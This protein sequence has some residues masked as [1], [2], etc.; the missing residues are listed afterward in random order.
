MAWTNLS[1]RVANVDNNAA[2]DIN[3]VME[4]LRL[5]KGGVA[6]T[7]PTTTLEA[8]AVLTDALQL[9]SGVNVRGAESGAI[10]QMSST[11]KRRQLF[12]LSGTANIKLPKTGVV[13]GWEYTLINPGAYA[14]TVNA[15][16][17]SPV[18]V[19]MNATLRVVAK[20]ATPEAVTDWQISEAKSLTV[21]KEYAGGA[22]YNTVALNVTSSA[23]G[24]SHVSSAFIPYQTIDGKWHVKGYVSATHDSVTTAGVNVA[25]IDMTNYQ[26]AAVYNG[27][28]YT[29]G[30]LFDITYHAAYTNCWFSFDQRLDSKPTWAD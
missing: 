28:A 26:A 13:E 24:F 25:G 14:L 6:G 19:T 22:T 11:D 5:I 18:C 17:G 8:E 12:A 15:N 2:A 16:S 9:D 29:T 27:W 4:D 20:V 7:A 3:A 23:A 1:T 21:E 10:T 30:T